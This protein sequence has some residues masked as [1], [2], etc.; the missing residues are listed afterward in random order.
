MEVCDGNRC[1]DWIIRRLGALLWR[2]SLECIH[3]RVVRASISNVTGRSIFFLFISSVRAQTQ[4]LLTSSEFCFR[5]LEG[6]KETAI[7][8]KKMS[9]RK[10]KKSG[11]CYRRT[12]K[13]IFLGICGLRD[14]L[15]AP[16][17]WFRFLFFS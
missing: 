8:T 15:S 11:A 5:V 13:T 10:P 2:D 12:N 17:L 7:S 16:G 9:R 3:A 14:L 1:G 4:V 6:G